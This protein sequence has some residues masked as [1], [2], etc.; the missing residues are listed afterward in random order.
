MTEI[1]QAAARTADWLEAHPENHIARSL[2]IDA[3]G[4]I[5]LPS[6]PTATC[7]CALGRL[8]VE[9]NLPL[10]YANDYITIE[11]AIG[12]VYEDLM[13]INDEDAPYPFMVGHRLVHAVHPENIIN[14]LRN[15]S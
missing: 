4:Q 7:F 8:A 14:A 2:A 10:S 12:P 5:V 9:L 15:L 6:S 1:Q 13:N 11:D 3:D